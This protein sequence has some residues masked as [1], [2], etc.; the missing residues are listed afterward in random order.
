MRAVGRILEGSPFAGRGPTEIVLFR[1]NVSR[2]RGGA[3]F[4]A[5]CRFG[6]GI[7]VQIPIHER[8][9]VMIDEHFR[10]HQPSRSLSGWWRKQYGVENKILLYH[11]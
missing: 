7:V 3:Q 5:D 4:L 6:A 10:E 9:P 1:Q 8:R 11:F 2:Q